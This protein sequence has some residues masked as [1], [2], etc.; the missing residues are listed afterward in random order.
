[1]EQG[2]TDMTADVN[3][4]LI[5][6]LAM[7]KGVFIYC[8]KGLSVYTLIHIRCCLSWSHLTE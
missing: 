7:E 2:L 1:M 5:E 6:T 8:T 3:F 4:G